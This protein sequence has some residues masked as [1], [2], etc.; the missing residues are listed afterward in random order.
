MAVPTRAARALGSIR[1][2]GRASGHAPS[3]TG[4]LVRSPSARKEIEASEMDPQTITRRE[5]SCAVCS[6]RPFVFCRKVSFP[7]RSLNV[8]KEAL[9]GYG[10]SKETRGSQ[11]SCLS[12]YSNLH[13]V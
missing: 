7:G 8:Y 3:E 11:P 4:D 12:A 2:S 1:R 6:S 5:S 9:G 10:F 13:Y